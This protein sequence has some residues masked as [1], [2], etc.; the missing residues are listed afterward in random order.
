MKKSVNSSETLRTYT[1]PSLRFLNVGIPAPVCT[2]VGAT[3][4]DYIEDDVFGGDN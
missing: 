1:Q 2:S 4:E 3:T